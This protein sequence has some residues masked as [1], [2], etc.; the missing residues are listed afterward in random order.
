MVKGLK[1]LIILCSLSFGI[2][3][4]SE[5]LYTDP[6]GRI[7]AE[8]SVEAEY[9]EYIIKADRVIY[10][11]QDRSIRAFGNVY[12]KKK[13]GSFEV[14]GTEAQL[15]AETGKGYF[16][17]AEGRFREFYITAKRVDRIEEDTYYIIE[18][19]V[20]TCP[21]ERKDLKICF[22]KAA[23]TEKHVF[24]FSNRLK[25]FNIPVAYSPLILFPIGE[26]RSGLL[27]PMIGSNT[28]NTFIYRQPLFIAIS[29]DKDATITFDYR[30]VQ[31][32][33]LWL[34]Y[35]QAFTKRDMFYTRFKYYRE[36]SPPGEWWSGRD[37]ETFRIDRWR[38]ELR[39][40]F[41]NLKLG[42]DLPSDPYFFEDI[43]FEQNIRAKPFTLSY[44]SYSSMDRDYLL[45][46]TARAYYDLTS[47]NNR[48][49]LNMLPEF[50]FYRRPA[51]VGPFYVNLT[52]AFTNFLREEGLKS[53]R[54]I[55]LPEVELPVSLWGNYNYTRIRFINNFYV[56]NQNFEDER[57]SSIYLEN[58]TPFFINYSGEKFTFLNTFEMVYT[59]SPE[60]FDNP[61][62]DS[63]D[64]VVKENNAKGRLTST[65]SYRGRSVSSLFLEAGYNLLKSYRFPTDRT[66]IE[67][68][69]LPIRSI[70]SLY[71]AS[72]L[73]LRHD[74][75]YDLNLRISASNV[76]TLTLKGGKNLISLSYATTRNSKDERLTDQYTANLAVDFKG[77]LLGARGSY[78]TISKRLIYA[79]GY[80]GYRGPCYF[81][82][83]DYRRTFYQNLNDYINEIFVV[84]NIF[85]LRDFKLPLRRR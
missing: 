48:R 14:L 5:R 49:T 38:L 63:Y 70:I 32:K 4:F 8:G 16:L 47:P 15:N 51:K 1:I 21:P 60:N 81:F 52:T 85:N 76:S 13:D 40:S 83:V 75:T 62:F 18:G 77:F 67:K 23:I 20:T 11:T 35:R 80:L 55:F 79:K 45:T 73:S 71:P 78:D 30:D 57:V 34:E 28:Y 66:L 10:N 59:F 33:G 46:F 65:L 58:R 22:W 69:L 25:L 43:Y 9:G 29:R 44:I 61:Q 7:T 24:S 82:R 64:V 17:D 37:P 27:P 68:E 74:T 54:L 56:T 12:I 42:F 39:T 84:F 3:I 72:W 36:P 26:R 19:D 6:S 41:K 2:E 50:N 31:A 53:Q